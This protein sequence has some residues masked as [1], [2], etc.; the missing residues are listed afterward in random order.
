MRESILPDG[1]CEPIAIIKECGAPHRQ[2]P[3]AKGR[4]IAG[5]C[6]AQDDP[7]FHTMSFRT[8]AASDAG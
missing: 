7:N 6:W 1:S 8:N 5:I 2:C 4:G 3:V